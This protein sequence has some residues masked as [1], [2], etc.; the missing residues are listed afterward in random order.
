MHSEQFTCDMCGKD[1]TASQCNPSYR[2]ALS[3][4]VIP[5]E[6]GFLGESMLYVTPPLETSSH[7]CG[8]YCLRDWLQSK[9][10]NCGD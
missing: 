10:S 4:E 7:F 6:R 9:T 8:W 1:L 2:L 3:C 5:T